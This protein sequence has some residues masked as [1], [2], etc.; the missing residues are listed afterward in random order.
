MPY[1][2]ALPN[3]ERVQRVLNWL[4]LPASQR[5]NLITLYFSD[6]DSAGHSFGPDAPETSAAVLKVDQSI[7]ELQEGLQS[8]S[9]P[10]NLIVV[11]DHGMQS[12]DQGTIGLSQFADLTGVRVISE[13]GLALVYAPDSQT[14]ERTYRALKGKS[15]L[16]DVYRRSETPEEWHLRENS[17]SGDLI[18]AARQPVRIVAAVNSSGTTKGGHGYDPRQFKTMLGIFYAI[19]PNIRPNGRVGSVENIHIAPFIARILNLKLPSRLDGSASVL[20][21]LYRP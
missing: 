9:L 5:P 19:G 12:I 7:G 15:P 1:D 6:V 14:A 20:E 16:F 11:S 13:G 3:H 18:V 8:L 10:V 21:S 4:R 2:G 17:R